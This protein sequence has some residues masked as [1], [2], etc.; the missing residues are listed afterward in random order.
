MSAQ[1]VDVLAVMDAM[2]RFVWRA[3]GNKN[4]AANNTLDKAEAARAAVAELIERERQ[5]RELLEA[6]CETYIANRHGIGACDFVKCVTPVGNRLDES[7]TGRLWLRAHNL[8]RI[9]GAQ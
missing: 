3:H 9:G 5:Q 6:L 7:E 8:V 4:E 1:P 2:Y